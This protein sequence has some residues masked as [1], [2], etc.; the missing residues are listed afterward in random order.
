ME[1]NQISGAIVDAA[2][3][4]HMQLGPGLLESVYEQC[5]IIELQDRGLR[6]ASQIPLPI[7]Y[8]G[9]RIDAA[10][11]LDVLV[12]DTVVVEIKAVEHVLPVQKAQ[13]VSYLRLSGKKL[14]LLLNFNVPRLRDG[15]FR[16]VNRLEETS[17]LP[18]PD[19]P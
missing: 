4:V 13:L 8:A 12:E 17:E 5:L 9:H 19:L 15:I 16:V 11:R 10:Y 6:C 14:G 3:H 18:L 1:I 2:L 7:I